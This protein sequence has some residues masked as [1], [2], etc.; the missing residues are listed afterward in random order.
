MKISKNSGDGIKSENAS[1][2]FGS[3]TP[4]NFSTHV[5]KS[6]PYY[7]IGHD[8]VVEISD[9]FVKEDSICYEIGVSTGVLIKKLCDRHKST[10][11]WVGIDKEKNMIEQAKHE[12]FHNKEKVKNLKLIVDDAITYKY[13][14][15][16]FIV[17]YYTIQFIPNRLRQ[18]ILDSIY[19]NL[20]WGGAFLMFEKVRGPD[21]RFQDVMT[22][23]Y[24]EFKLKQGYS[25]EEIIS[26]SRSLKGV[27][28]PFSTKGNIEML[29]RAGFVD[30]LPIFKWVCFEGYLC[31]K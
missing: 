31:I 19:S 13:K 3:D 21:A 5:K 9:Y 15:S 30:I 25:P 14:K 18:V 16:D 28:E 26:K 22:G 17:S 29:K 4:K 12:V 8:L 2:T 6:V 24:N 7:D 20:N 11:T 1:W 27:M 23:I 10:T